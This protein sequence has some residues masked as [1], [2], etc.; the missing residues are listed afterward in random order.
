[1]NNLT[2]SSGSQKSIHV[3]LS[4]KPQYA[5]AI[6]CGKKRFEFRRTNF[7]RDIN[8]VVVYVT[9]PIKR[10]VA[11]FDVEEVIS[12]SIPELWNQTSKYAGIDKEY[13]FQ[14][15]NGKEIGYAL[16]IGSV[17]KYKSPFCPFAELNVKPP[18]SFVYLETHNLLEL[19]THT[20]IYT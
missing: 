17:R 16:K 2:Q 14:Y 19:K 3:L 1:M 12:E 4:I 9:A 8:V 18:Q 15:F 7:S 10:V 20:T 5:S 11:E 6:L 13:F